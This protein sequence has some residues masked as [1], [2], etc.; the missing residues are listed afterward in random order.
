MQYGIDLRNTK[1]L[2]K[3]VSVSNGANIP[4]RSKAAKAKSLARAEQKAAEIARLEAEAIALVQLEAERK[5]VE[6]RRAADKIRA[7]ERREEES[8][9]FNRHHDNIDEWW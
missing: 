5:Q 3:K 7:D 8:R 1:M 2:I 9:E 6:I 4:V